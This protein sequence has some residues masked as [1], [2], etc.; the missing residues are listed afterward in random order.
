MLP[1]KYEA[2]IQT[3]VHFIS[4]SFPLKPRNNKVTD[5]GF[6]NRK[7]AQPTFMTIF[8]RKLHQIEKMD[9]GRHV[10]WMMEEYIPLM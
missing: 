7:W 10:A 2:L 8:S 4:V 9:Q 5:P 6:C 3:D 1:V